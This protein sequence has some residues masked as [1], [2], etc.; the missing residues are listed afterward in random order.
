MLC[1][2]AGGPSNGTPVVWKSTN[3]GVNFSSAVGTGLQLDLFGIWGFDSLNAIAVDGGGPNGIGGNARVYRTTNG[4]LVWTTVLS[5]GGSN[6][7]FNGVVFSRDNPQSGIVQSD[8]PSVGQNYYIRLTTNGGSSWDSIGCPPV[9]NQLG[10]WNS[11]IFIDE[12]F[13]GFC[14]GNKTSVRLTTDGG[15]SWNNLPTGL[16]GGSVTGLGFHSD[17][18][19]GVAA[20][21]SS[22]PNVARTTDGGANWNIFS[23]GTTI[24]GYAVVKWVW[25][26][27]VFYATG[28]SGSPGTVMR[29]TN[30]G[31]TWT[32]MTVPFFAPQVLNMDFVKDS[33]DVI[34]GYAC[35]Q[36]GRVF[37]LE[38]HV[39]I[40]IN[41][42][43]TTVPVDFI[44]EQN[45]PNPFNPNTV[46]NYSVPK[47]AFVTIKIYDLLGREVKTLISKQHNTGNYTET[48]D[49]S[50]LSSGIYYY[51]MNAD[52]Y[53]ETKKMVLVK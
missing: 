50:G 33:N 40:G 35:T 26:T 32:Q 53:Y 10:Q 41:P 38:D 9:G 1:G 30:G 47:S 13:F 29:S 51:T 17:K 48:F 49:G 46:I 22:L 7:F 44:L 31:V 6:G 34:W 45:Y 42:N 21:N 4:G 23:S 19:T 52:E 15:T 28:V 37:K 11:V 2:L 18:Q 8:I 3:G 39:L 27:N 43:N 14:L 20:S 16:A 36:T 24:T 12:M 5:T 25:G